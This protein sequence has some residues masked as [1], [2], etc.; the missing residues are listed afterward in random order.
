MDYATYHLLGEPE[1]TIEEVP[2]KGKGGATLD[3]GPSFNLAKGGPRGF[4]TY[5]APRLSSSKN[6]HIPKNPEKKLV[7][8][9]QVTSIGRDTFVYFNWSLL[10][11]LLI[12]KY[13]LLI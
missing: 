7:L 12:M 8:S 9:T 3:W 11:L 5:F 4:V 6:V 10:G 2:G 1:T 13:I